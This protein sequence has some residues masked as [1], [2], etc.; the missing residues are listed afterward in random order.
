[1]LF[2]VELLGGLL[3]SSVQPAEY[4][5]AY[6]EYVLFDHICLVVYEQGPR[7]A[8]LQRCGGP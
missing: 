6:P 5:Y 1:M 4:S 7:A 8:C 3:E 2:P